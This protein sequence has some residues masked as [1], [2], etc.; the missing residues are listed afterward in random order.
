MI[1]SKTPLRS[2]QKVEVNVDP[3]KI[4]QGQRRNKDYRITKSDYPEFDKFE[5][6]LHFQQNMDAIEDRVRVLL[7]SSK[8]ARKKDWYL[9][10]LYWAKMGYIKL[11]IPQ[12]QLNKICPP[13]SITRM[14]RRLF[15]KA[16]KGDESLKWLLY[17]EETLDNREKQEERYHDYFAQRKS[18]EVAKRVK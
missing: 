5:E 2:I 11:I 7:R 13:E 18:E 9:L 12:D 8:Y 16:K 6:S 4:I 15:E 3:L 10:L 1:E 17:D 14:R